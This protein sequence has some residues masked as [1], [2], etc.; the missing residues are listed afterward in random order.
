MYSNY[1]QEM[2]WQKFHLEINY[3]IE[4]KYRNKKKRLQ[5]WVS[6]AFFREVNFELNAMPLPAMLIHRF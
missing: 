3:S 6:F 2:F 1:R 5:Y 4:I